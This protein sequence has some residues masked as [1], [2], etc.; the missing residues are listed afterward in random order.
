MNVET[1]AVAG[2]DDQIDVEF[3]VKEQPTGSL[4]GTLGYS[5]YSGLILGASFQE[6][7]VGGT[8]NS[9]GLGVSWSKYMKSINYN[10]FDPYFTADGISRG[11]NLSFRE[12]DYGGRNLARFSTDSLGGGVNFGFPL[13]ETQRLQFSLT[14]EHTEITQGFLTRETRRRRMQYYGVRCVNWRAR[15]R[16]HELLTSLKS[17]WSD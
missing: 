13:S 1:P 16:Q 17:G 3:S 10:F 5:E 15:G 14:V 9:F 2:R 8:G 7:N 12:T 4:S 11:Y 6:T